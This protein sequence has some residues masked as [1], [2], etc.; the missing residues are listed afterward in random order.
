MSPGDK[1]QDGQSDLPSRDKFRYR[2]ESSLP[3]LCVPACINMVLT[4]RGYSSLPQTEIAS[5]LGLV[6]PQRMSDIYPF[7]EISED[8]CAWGVR[9]A[10][11]EPRI[12]ALLAE[13]AP[14]LHHVFRRWQEVPASSQLEFV[15]E[16][17]ASGNDVAVGFR[18]SDIYTGAAPVGHVALIME[19]DGLREEV[20]LMD[21][22][23]GTEEGVV[24]SWRRLLTGI[25]AVQDGYWLFGNNPAE[26]VTGFA[27]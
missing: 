18:A 25:M 4:R 26:L 22:Q 17:L 5:Q 15:A 21:P 6:A 23:V 13:Q 9:S 20:R 14:A 24:V 16:H 7:A 8:P 1:C 11:V 3:L 2:R 19:V 10:T 27:I 12:R